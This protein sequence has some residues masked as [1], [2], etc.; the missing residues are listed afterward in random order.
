[1]SRKARFILVAI[2][3]LAFFGYRQYRDRVGDAPADNKA[4]ASAGAERPAAPP[5]KPRMLG[6][7]AFE[8]C[9]LP[10]QMGAPGVEAQCGSLSVAENPVEPEGRR[11]VLNIAWIPADE[12]GDQQPDPVFLL[13]GG[14]GQSATAS[15]P[16][17]APAFKDVLKQRG[18]VLVDQRGTG[19]SNPLQ[20]AGLAEAD[21]PADES[22]MLEAMRSAVERCRDALSERADLRFYTTTDA[23]RDLDAVRQAIGADAINLPGISYGTRRAQQHARP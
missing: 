5:A 8:P 22:A 3:L 21:M 13:A 4:V 20:C 17:V 10:A 19:K 2:V 9:T 1:M 14:P 11:I 12:D 18:V 15:Y 7:I 6:S 23:V 16:A